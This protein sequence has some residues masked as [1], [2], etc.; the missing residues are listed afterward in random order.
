IMVLLTI[1][2]SSQPPE[3]VKRGGNGQGPAPKVVGQVIDQYGQPIPYANIALYSKRDSTLKSGAASDG[4]GKFS[5]R[6]RPGM[7]YAKISFLSYQEKL[8]SDIKVS[9][10]GADLGTIKLLNSSE[11]LDEVEIR[12]ETSQMELKLD[13]RVFNVGKDL[14][15]TGG[16]AAD[17]LDNVPSV[18]V[19]IEGNVSLRGSE[20]VRILIDG[21]Q[22]GLVGTSTT[23]ALR[24]L[25]GS[26]IEK[27]EVITNPSARYDAEGEVGIINIVLKKGRENGWNGSIE[28]TAG[29]P[30]NYRASFS[31]NHRTRIRNFFASYGANYRKTP[32]SGSSLQEFFGDTTFVFDREREHTRSGL[33]HNLRLGT[34]LF[35]N[36]M[37]T[38]TVSGLYKVSDG[39]NDARLIYRDL[40]A[41]MDLIQIVK[42]TEDEEEDQENIEISIGHRKTYDAKGKEWTADFKWNTN[43]D[44]EMSN[45]LEAGALDTPP[46]YQRVNNTEDQENILVQTDY[47]HPFSKNGVMELGL[48][49]TFRTIENKYMVEEQAADDSWLILSEFNNHFIYQEN[50]MAAYLMAGNKLGN[51]SYQCGLR[52]EYSDIQTELLASNEKNPRNYTNFFPSLHI[53]QQLDTSNTLQ[54]SYSRRLSRPRFRH[55]LPFFTFSDSRNFYSGNP[56]LDPEFTNAFELGHLKYMEKGSVLSSIYYRH[57]NNIIQRITQV[58]STGSTRIFP[59]NLGTQDAFGLEFN[60]SYNPE[61]W[62]RLNANFN[63]FRAITE[64]EFE[65]RD[66]SADAYTWSCRTTSRWTISKTWDVQAS[67]N[68]RAPRI[69]IQG[70]RKSMYNLDIGISRDILK[71]KG[72]LVLSAKDI[73][74]TRKRRSITEGPNF[75]SESEFQWRARQ[76]L[77]SFSYR[78]K[79]EKK[80]RGKRNSR[81]EFDGG[82]EEGF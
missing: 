63:F 58:D 13:K 68:Y 62:W 20:N 22:S 64:G 69:S 39:F 77:I 40:D 72:T 52:A 45:L 14:A 10:E 48:K 44:T 75:F 78:L 9:R 6:S 18:T 54:L 1:V 60:I 51:F 25:Q 76:F 43:D 28:L 29:Y 42:R 82:V 27:V 71:K 36:K 57:R 74:N 61:K 12:A 30:D 24:Q 4:Q 17:I 3:G 67:F 15:N 80:S 11:D 49:G 2:G 33:G 41:N 31:L 21:K 23:D 65:G 53:S 73:L 37:N 8:I 66:F 34:E 59:I 35:L 55:L 79:H 47:I 32:G 46:I 56:D 5:I 26:L 70:K 16:N 19:D 38:L 7:Y 81:N 50:I